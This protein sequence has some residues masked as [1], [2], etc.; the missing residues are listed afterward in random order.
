MK[1]PTV[2]AEFDPSLVEPKLPLPNL[3]AVDPD[4][5]KLDVTDPADANDAEKAVNAWLRTLNGFPVTS[6][7]H[8]DFSGSLDARTVS[9]DTVK[10]YEVNSNNTVTALTPKNIFFDA[11]KNRLSIS[12]VWRAGRT[13]AVALIGGANGLKGAGGEAVVGSQAFDLLRATYPL[14]TCEQLTDATCRSANPGIRGK[15]IDDERRRALKMEKARL[16]AA[17]VIEALES[18][19][20]ARADLAT[21]F[22][23]RTQTETLFDPV[24]NFEPAV[25][26]I[27]FPNDA[28]LVDGHPKLPEEPG[29]DALVAETKAELGRL[30]GFSTTAHI[31]TERN[32]VM[33][34]VGTGLLTGSA[35]PAHFQL[36]DTE[37]GNAN[38]PFTLVVK[39]APDQL[40][41]KPDKPLRSHHKYAVVWTKGAKTISGQD[42]GPSP[43]WTMLTA[44][45]PFT[46]AMGKSRV[47]TLED[48][49][50]QD[51]ER[52]R[53]SVVAGLSAA[54]AKGI[55]RGDV[56][57]AWTFTT[58]TTA[59][60]LVELRNKPAQWNLPTSV[61]NVVD[62]TQV[63]QLSLVS[64]FAGKDFHSHIRSGKEG[65]YVTGNALDLMGHELDLT[66]PEAPVTV[67]TEG[68]FTDAT[69]MT[70]RQ[71]QLKFLLVLP[72]VPKH[73]DGRIPVII[74]QHGITRFRRDA[75]FM[76]NA[77]ARRGFATLAIDHPMHGDRSYC[78]S[79][80]DCAM[81]FMCTA[82]RC[83][84]GG[85]RPE[86]GLEGQLLGTPAVSGLKFSSTTN[87]AATRD[88]MRQLVIDT[89]QLV[90]VVKDTTAG[91]GSIN[92]DDPMTPSVTER[93]DTSE[94]GYIGMSLGSVMGS[95]AVSANP[96]ITRATFNVGGASPAD[97]LTQANVAFLASKKQALDRYLTAARGISPG[98]QAYD[99]FY[100]IARWMLDTADAQNQGRH[101]IDEPLPGFPKKRIFLSWVQD[102]PWVPN[103]T[104]RLL[105]NAI[106][107]TTAP[108]NFGEHMWTGAARGDHS[109]MMNPN[110]ADVL[111]AQ[112]EAVAWID[113]P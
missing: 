24:V 95:L 110:F 66:N 65:V 87:L 57:L 72:K 46:D 71:E 55:A 59:P 98:T 21:V 107:R 60:T 92:V 27:P 7:A 97:I 56:L 83:P 12:Y 63:G 88:Q 111:A 67:E 37:M 105:I 100:D 58:Q 2:V 1:P 81:G 41:L 78:T 29:D 76:A 51:L 93:L 32:M 48:A 42:I 104:T 82:H 23:F 77:I 13:Y 47:R 86:G 103:A 38:A 31:V 89:A 34:A 6:V 14:V 52:L 74:F 17:P 53:Q 80:A 79:N 15:T 43:A 16:A 45:A 106:E 54:E 18:A 70:P 19:N 113:A 75:L 10:L 61:T 112:D 68:P 22:T 101:Y 50:A 73:A 44:G 108:A 69:L 91:I 96:E 11:E 33:N 94:L 3:L 39:E 64:Q 9:A 30:D 40:S 102:D 26:A 109:F 90:R 8:V 36:L 35:Q 25:R 20:V 85:Y 49:Q 4:T 99:D 62:L 5:G 28:L 84:P